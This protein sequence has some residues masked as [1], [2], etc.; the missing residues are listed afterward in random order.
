MLGTVNL[1]KPSLN[2]VNVNAFEILHSLLRL[3]IKLRKLLFQIITVTK[4]PTE[5]I[6][7][8]NLITVDCFF[9][10]KQSKLYKTCCFIQVSTVLDSIGS[11]PRCYGPLVCKNCYIWVR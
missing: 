8:K 3:N 4:I 2:K 11:G 6:S 1:A 5:T 7:I 10:K 9:N